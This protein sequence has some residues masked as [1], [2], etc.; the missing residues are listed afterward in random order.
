MIR[1]WGQSALDRRELLRIGGLALGGLSLPAL[2][3]ANPTPARRGGSF[4]RAKSCIV[5]YLSGG[6]A[7]LD[8]F[9]PKPDAPDDI[10][11]E[12]ATIQ[13]RLP[14]VRF[15]ELLPLAA[16]WTHKTA[17]VRTLCHDH[18]DHGR[19]S[20]WMFTGYPYP[21]SVPDVNNMNRQD[22]PPVG[23]VVSKLAPGPGP[24]PAWALVPHRMDVAGGRRAGQFAGS[25]GPRFDP[26][27]T[28]GNPNDDGYKLENLPLVAN[29][30][31]DVV[32]RRLSLVDQLNAETAPLNSL[33]MSG[34]IRDGQ[35]RAVE[36][37]SSEAVRRAVDLSAVPTAERERYG[38]NLFGQSVLLGSRLLGA[39][40]R[41]VQCN[42]QRTQGINGFAWD[43]H[44]NNFTAHKDDL[45][46][47]FDRA[48][49][50]LMTDLER[51]GRLDETL[52]VVAAE[53]GRT[54]KI[55]R[56]NAGRE[57]HPDCFSVVFAGGG[58]RGGQVVGQSDRIAAR[59]STPPIPPADF[60]ATMYHLLGIDPGAEAH[61]QGGRPFVLSRGTPIREL[62]G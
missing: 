22:M 40:V 38:R 42:W 35:A 53:F 18:N 61:D 51:T 3:R 4:G 9:D 56:S 39:G 20:Y 19:G 10:R 32:R 37:L 52:V 7:Q 31:P 46:P 12:F 57:H 2:T 27:L 14:G 48:F 47:P 6:P 15:S 55:T 50:A 34:T 21:G 45:V 28:G 60:T 30:P 58:V 24:L 1:L 23:A 54:P 62:I 36:V 59:P 16:Q 17:V 5:L 29:E 49:H 44:W 8:T 43:T 13:T 41:L 26:L 33:A 11:G 25:L